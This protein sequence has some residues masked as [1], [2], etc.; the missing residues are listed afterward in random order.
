MI[1][2]KHHR[3]LMDEVSLVPLKMFCV[4]II[5]AKVKLKHD[6]PQMFAS[7]RARCAHESYGAISR[8][9]PDKEEAPNVPPA[10]VPSK[11]VTSKCATNKCAKCQAMCHMCQTLCQ[12]CH[13]SKLYQKQP[14]W[15]ARLGY[16]DDEQQ[17]M[18]ILVKAVNRQS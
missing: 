17:T 9:V 1:G 14:N 15:R 10:S 2:A 8:P 13:M 18:S 5:L 12:M 11:R 3:E 7:A 6:P 16:H 4:R